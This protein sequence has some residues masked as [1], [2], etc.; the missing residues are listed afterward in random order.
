MTNLVGER[1][2]LRALE[3][4]DL[5]FLYHLENDTELWEVSGTTTPYSR[6]LLKQYLDNAHRDVYEV[7]Q[8]RLCIVDKATKLSIGLIDLF[9]FDPK[10]KRAGLGLV[11]QNIENRNNGLGSEAVGLMLEYGFSILDLRQ[12]YVNV[13]ES[14]VASLH[15]FK[16]LGFI[17]VG[18]KRDWIFSEGEYKNEVLLQKIK[19]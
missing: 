18:I 15:L 12:L 9:E 13:L 1:L 19:S 3:D 10:N 6:Y 7:K 11:I 5:D 2:V 16:K 4:Q 8:L 17:E 14:N